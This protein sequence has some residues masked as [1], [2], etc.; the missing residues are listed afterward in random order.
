MKNNIIIFGSNSFIARS[1]IE[2]NKANFENIFCID[3]VDKMSIDTPNNLIYFNA[4]KI[5]SKKI[6]VKLKKYKIK[7]AINFAWIGTSGP[8]R[9]NWKHQYQNVLNSIKNL[10]L[11][12]KLNVLKF[13]NFGSIMENEL[14]LDVQ[15]EKIFPNKLYAL[16]KYNDHILSKIYCDKNN[17]EF[18]NLIITNTFGVGENSPRL[19]NSIIDNYLK[20]NSMNFS[21]CNQLYSFLYIDE[22]INILFLLLEKAKVN[23]R[24]VIGDS[25]PNTLKDYIQSVYDTLNKISG[26]NIQPNFNSVKQLSLKKEDLDT[27]N[28]FRD[29]EYT[30]KISF[31]EGIKKTYDW[32]S[33]R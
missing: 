33:K 28:T 2:K 12:K 22:L 31:E 8:L 32:K 30:I 27:K 9:E 24:Y 5:N 6:Y 26:K 3:I 4:S 1:F 25:K 16:A 15:N 7:Y 17:I 18:I 20:N 29:T 21:M 10:K 11:C 23:C 14:F 19:I 13:F